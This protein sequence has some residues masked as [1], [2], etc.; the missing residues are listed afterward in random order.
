[1]FEKN[2]FFK[3][4]KLKK[5][6]LNCVGP[7]TRLIRSKKFF[8]TSFYCSPSRIKPA[9]FLDSPLA[10][11]GIC[12][13]FDMAIQRIPTYVESLRFYAVGTTLTLKC[14]WVRAKCKIYKSFFA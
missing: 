8:P 5:S 7:K 13:T 12:G 2:D 11:L 4:I 9:L 14:E 1:V 6:E 3:V 10:K